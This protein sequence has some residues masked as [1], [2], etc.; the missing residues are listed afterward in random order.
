MEALT[1]GF[2]LVQ[3]MIIVST[4]EVRL[5]RLCSVHATSVLLYLLN[6]AAIANITMNETDQLYSTCLR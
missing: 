2:G 1:L 5:F 4:Q 3:P 6:S